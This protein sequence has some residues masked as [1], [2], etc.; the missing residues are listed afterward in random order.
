MENREVD[1]A[2]IIAVCGL[3]CAACEAYIATQAGDEAA[4]E[5]VAAKWRVQ[6][7]SLKIDAKSITCDGCLSDTGR[8]CGHCLEC[9]PR[10]CAVERG[11]PNCAHC[12][13]FGC[14]KIS[15]LLKFIPDA[16][17]RLDEIRAGL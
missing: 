10:L 5:K 14:K 11:L 8:L 6:Y 2:Q 15:G 12:P 3:D 13:D 9:G 4:K 16:K 17:T 7:N 1:V